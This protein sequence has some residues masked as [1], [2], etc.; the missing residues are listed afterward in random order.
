MPWPWNAGTV[1]EELA[2][3]QR[4]VGVVLREH[5]GQLEAALDVRTGE[6]HERGTEGLLLLGVMSCWCGRHPHGSALAV[7]GQVGLT[8]RQV[9]PDVELEHRL[10]QLG[11]AGAVGHEPAVTGS[12]KKPAA[13]V[14]ATR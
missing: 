7:R 14:A 11:A 2:V 4:L 12:S 1:D 10:R 13:T 3:V 5:L 6:L 8:E 9:R